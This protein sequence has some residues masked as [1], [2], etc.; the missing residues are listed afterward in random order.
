M[1][2][3]PIMT[4]KD[5][6][7]LRECMLWWKERLFLHDWS[8]SAVLSDDVHEEGEEKQLAGLNTFQII[9]MTSFIQINTKEPG[10]MPTSIARTCQ[11][12]TLVHEL[13]HLRMNWLEAPYNHEGSYYEAL[14]HQKIEQFARS[15]ILAKYQLPPDWFDNTKGDV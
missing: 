15:L 9:H 7:Q 6:A 3:E 14:E 1:M 4:F 2:T 11:E 12:N 10:N 13:L 8:I 5:N